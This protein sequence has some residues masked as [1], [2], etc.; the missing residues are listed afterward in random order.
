MMLGLGIALEIGYVASWLKYLDLWR[1]SG[2][3]LDLELKYRGT[4]R[5]AGGPI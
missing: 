2:P 5:V 4:R 1:N 3:R